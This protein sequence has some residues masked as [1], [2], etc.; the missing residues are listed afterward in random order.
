MK[1]YIITIILTLC[2]AA[3]KQYSKHWDTLNTIENQMNEN[4][5][6]AWESLKNLDKSSYS[7]EELARY[8]LLSTSLSVYP[9]AGLTRYAHGGVPKYVVDPNLAIIPTGFTHIKDTATR[10]VA[11]WVEEI[12]NL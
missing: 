8:A 9:A 2:L 4:P 7:D 12:K 5:S 3:C 6:E 1:Q 10:S 11:R